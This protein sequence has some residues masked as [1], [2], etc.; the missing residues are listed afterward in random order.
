MANA[1]NY[2]CNT[3]SVQGNYIEALAFFLKSLNLEEKLE[4]KN[5]KDKHWFAYSFKCIT[6]GKNPLIAVANLYIAL[7]KK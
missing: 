7:N 1:Y 4:N 6:H 2:I 5:D 3:Y